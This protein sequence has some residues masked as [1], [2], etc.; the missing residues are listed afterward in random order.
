MGHHYHELVELIAF[1][2]EVITREEQQF[3]RTLNQGLVRL[4]E[5]TT[6]LQAE[7]HTIVPGEEIFRL[8]DTYVFPFELTRDVSRE[9]G[10][11][12]DEAGFRKA[13]AQQKARA[14]E[15]GRHTQSDEAELYRLLQLPSTAFWGTRRVAQKVL[16]SLL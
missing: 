1:I 3:L 5:L 4:D 9:K 10:F 2:R 16:S 11:T 13:M 7:G 12:V 6:R 14:R 15:K 8:Y